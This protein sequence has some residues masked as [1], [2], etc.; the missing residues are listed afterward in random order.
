MKLR[1]FYDSLCPLCDAEMQHIKARDIGDDIELQDLNQS[2]FASKFP[3]IDFTVANRILH[4]QRPDGSII[5]GLDVTYEA[6]TVVGK[7]RWVSLLRCSLVK[8]F[9]DKGYLFFAKHR[10]RI[11]YLLTGKKRCESGT[12]SR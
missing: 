9:A 5:T 10:Y 8:P 6:W 1:I 3:E 11:S 7:E 4:A 12:C 2:D